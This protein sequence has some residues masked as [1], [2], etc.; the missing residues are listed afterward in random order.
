MCNEVVQLRLQFVK[1]E[2]MMSDQP[3]K[4]F[5]T[6]WESLG[7]II[8]YVSTRRKPR[9]FERRKETAFSSL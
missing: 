2:I 8:S 6:K 9:D 1:I 5:K 3:T 7:E 4:F